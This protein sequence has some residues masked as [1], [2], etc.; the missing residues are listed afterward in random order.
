MTG[1]ARKLVDVPQ[2]ADDDGLPSE[3]EVARRFAAMRAAGPSP[4]LTP[5]GRAALAELAAQGVPEIN[6]PE[7]MRLPDDD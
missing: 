7:T 4:W 2:E 6:G 3:A 1:E 5:E